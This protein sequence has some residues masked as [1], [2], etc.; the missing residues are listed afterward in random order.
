VARC[1]Y[2]KSETGLFD[3]GMPICLDC[4]NRLGTK[5]QPSTAED[6]LARL[7]HEL[8]EATLRAHQA[9][10]AFNA[11]MGDIPS[12]VPQPDGTQ[13]INNVYRELSLAR[14]EM[15]RAHSCLTHFLDSGVVPEEDLE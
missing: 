13:R 10:D 9:T 15:M 2:C 1:G 7:Q 4:A 11:I 6:S 3:S 5:Q 14:R 12:A 8:K